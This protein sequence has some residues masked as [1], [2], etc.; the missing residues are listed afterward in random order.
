MRAAL[1]WLVVAMVGLFALP[2]WARRMAR[3]VPWV[4]AKLVLNTARHCLRTTLDA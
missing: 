2:A 1:V 3:V 4:G